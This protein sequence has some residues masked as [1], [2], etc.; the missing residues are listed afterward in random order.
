AIV[1]AAMPRGALPNMVTIGAAKCGTTALHSY[2]GRHPETSMSRP[3]EL[4]F[5]VASHNWGRGLDWYRSHFD[6]GA[7]VRGESSHLYAGHPVYPGA[8]EKMARV[9]PDAKLILLVRDPIDR[10]RAHWAHNYAIR[11]ERRPMREAVL[12]DPNYISRSSYHLQLTRFLEHYPRE[13]I[14]VLEQPDLASDPAATL[15]RVGEFLGLDPAGW[16]TGLDV[17]SVETARLR[18][19]TRLGAAIERRVARPTWGRLKQSP[20]LTRPFTPPEIDP[21]LRAELAERLRDDAARFRELTG[22]PFASWS[23]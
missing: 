15:A 18:R 21:E 19:R 6:P 5:F 14:L 23:V 16:P 2:L 13:Q 7:K 4:N 20:L 11:F 8:A 17:R 3:K 9:I 22:R 1:T 12:E 10:I